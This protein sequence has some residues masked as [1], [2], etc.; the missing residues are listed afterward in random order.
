[1]R[2]IKILPKLVKP[3]APLLLT[4]AMI[5]QPVFAHQ[6]PQR[7][8]ELHGLLKQLELTVEQ[9]SSIG[10]LVKQQRDNASAAQDGDLHQQLKQLIQ[11]DS[12]DEV[13]VTNI[14]SSRIESSTQRQLQRAQLRHQI[15]SLLTTEQQQKWLDI[16]DDRDEWQRPPREPKLSRL[17]LTEDQQQQLQQLR[18]EMQA[19]QQSFRTMMQ[20]L[21]EQ[22]Q[23]LVT[24]DEFNQQQWLLLAEQQQPKMLAFAVEQAENRHKVWQLL[25]PEQQQKLQQRMERFKHRAGDKP[26]HRLLS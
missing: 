5:T 1:M 8:G 2:A 18:S 14:L 23:A 22:E 10:D 7:M 26:R 11:A 19:S 16:S 13:A 15:W 12:F 24:S 25:T 4:V 9:K 17:D 20:E 3:A 21:R 6:G